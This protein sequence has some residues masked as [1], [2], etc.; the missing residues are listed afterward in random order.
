MSHRTDP[1]FYD[2]EVE[3]IKTGK[4]SCSQV[5]AWWTGHHSI[6]GL[7]AMC[8]CQLAVY[9][10]AES[11]LVMEPDGKKRVSWSNAHTI[12]QQNYLKVNSC[13]HGRAKKFRPVRAVL[14]SGEVV[15]LK[16]KAAA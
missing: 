2:L 5:G 12:A 11:K 1:M 3:E 7:H 14:P 16:Q 9:F 13:E 4:V 6:G 8:D 10:Y 15:Q